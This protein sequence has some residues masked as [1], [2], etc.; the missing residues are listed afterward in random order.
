MQPESSDGFASVGTILP[1]GRSC[2]VAGRL[3]PL[4]RTISRS[5]D[6]NHTFSAGRACK[7]RNRNP[8]PRFIC[9]GRRAFA[10]ASCTRSCSIPGM[11]IW[12]R[13]TA[14]KASARAPPTDIG[15]HRSSNHQRG[16]GQGGQQTGPESH[17]A[18]GD[19]QRSPISGQG[20]AI[21]IREQRSH[22]DRKQKT[23]RPNNRDPE[24]KLDSLIHLVVPISLNGRIRAVRRLLNF[25]EARRDDTILEEHA[26]VAQLVEQLIRNQQVI[27][28]SPIVGSISAIPSIFS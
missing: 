27:G 24:R 10:G 4:L 12:R 15:Q 8:L 5:K 18:E 23:R 7:L 3:F 16:D 13:L 20:K 19:E 21:L 28:S 6:T 25:T 11:T 17:P 2:P 9:C 22:R 1:K 26:D 14:H